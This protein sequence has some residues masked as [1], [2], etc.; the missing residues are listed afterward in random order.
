MGSIDSTAPPQ[1]LD[2]TWPRSNDRGY[3]I[4]ERPAFSPTRKSI[5]GIG[6]GMAGIALAMKANE[7][8]D[9]L[10]LKV[11]EKGSNY[12]GNWYWNQYPGLAC[13]NPGV[14]YQYIK[15]TIPDWRNFYSRGADIR[16]YMQSIVKKNGLEK[17][18]QLNTEVVS[19]E[20][21]D[22][23]AKWTVTVKHVETGV[24]SVETA[25]VVVSCT[26][27]LHHANWPDLKNASLYKGVYIHASRFPD[28]L[29]LTGKRVAVLG[30]GASGVQ[31]VPAIVNKASK[32][33]HWIRQ[34]T[35]ILPLDSSRADFEY[36]SETMKRFEED[37]SYYL[38]YRK[39]LEHRGK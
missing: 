33:Y 20:W 28:N 36:S 11:F 22:E 39:A 3:T 15:D 6:A 8:S 26:G 23:K 10:D 27:P 37:P 5:I 14:T 13:D 31:I 38:K 1:L 17:Y 7:R 12:G 24:I 4:D 9:L 18:F 30:T 32:V 25:D 19:A 21:S 2:G 35:Y 34:P 16:D 29:D